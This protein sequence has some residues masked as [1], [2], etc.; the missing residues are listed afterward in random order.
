MSE[1]QKR[2]LDI[3]QVRSLSKGRIGYFGSKKLGEKASISKGIWPDVG[4]LRHFITWLCLWLLILQSSVGKRIENIYCSRWKKTGIKF[5]VNRFKKDRPRC[6]K[7]NQGKICIAN[8]ENCKKEYNGTYYNDR[9]KYLGF[10]QL[11]L[12]RNLGPLC[13]G[14]ELN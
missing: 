1:T 8:F 3:E 14:L 11:E 4:W 12:T 5:E 13:I 10:C 9:T 2:P 6:K 7:K